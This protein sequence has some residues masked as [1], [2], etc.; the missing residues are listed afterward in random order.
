MRELKLLH[1]QIIL[2]G[3]SHETLTLGKLISFCAVAE[4]G[5]LDYARLVFEQMPHPNKFMYNSLIRGYSNVGDSMSAIFL[6]RKMI[7][8]GLSPNEFTIPFVL[9]ACT[10][11]S[12]HWEAVVV[13]GHTIKLGIGSQ[14]CVQNVLISVY[15]VYGLVPC[16]WKVFDEIL[17]RTLVSWNSIIGGYSKMDCREEAFL[18]FQEMRQSGMEPDEFTLVSLLSVCSRGCDLNLGRYLHLYIVI[19]GVNVDLI[20]RNALVDM[21]AKCGHLHSAEMVFNQ[22]P[23]KNVVSWT[24][25]VT[26]Y[27]RLGLTQSAQEIFDKMPVKNVVSW[28]SMISSY[29]QEGRCMQA[30]DLFHKMCDLRVVPDEATLVS[31]FSACT[32]IGDLIMGKKIHNYLCSHNLM[33]SVTIYNSL[34]DMYAKCGALRIAVDI[35][36]EIPEKNLVSWNVIIGALALY[37]C[38]LEAIDLFERM[39]AGGI[40]PDEITFTGLLSACGHSGLVDLGRY[41]FDKM[42]SNF[43]ISPEIEHYACMVDLLGRKGLL[44]EAIRLIGRMPLKPDVVVWGAVLRACRTYGNIEVARQIL[45]QLLV[46][47]PQSSGLYVLLANIYC[48]AERW[49]DVKKIRKM[50]NDHGIKKWKANSFIEIDGCIHEFLVDDKRHG[51]S[52]SI[53]SILGQLT[54]H[55]KSI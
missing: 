24:S 29:V 27:A 37:G 10:L 13:H 2:H 36:H 41:Y 21:Y 39:Q 7:R 18:L 54:D 16:A 48:E 44:E 42:S 15:F 45:K 43:G 47:E 19:T 28:N 1:A 52:S 38:G 30:L 40:R 4:T 32:Q 23:D 34:V 33:P 50:M 5:S 3:L 14:V 8:S 26:A 20:V 22:M 55:L 9:K 49:E 46:M 35:F 25:M 12:A 53:Y 51:I 31:V 6:Y 11:R 17:E